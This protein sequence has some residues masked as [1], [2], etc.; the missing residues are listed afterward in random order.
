MLELLFFSAPREKSVAEEAV[1]SRVNNMV[2]M[3]ESDKSKCNVILTAAKVRLVTCD[4]RHSI[5]DAA[6]RRCHSAA[7]TWATLWTS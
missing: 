5:S 2:N 1:V 7:K 6:S 4:T 3:S